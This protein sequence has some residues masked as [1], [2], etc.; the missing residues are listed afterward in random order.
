MKVLAHRFVGYTEGNPFCN[1]Q[2][3]EYSDS[4]I[5]K[6]FQPTSIFW[7]LFNE[8]H[9]LIIGSRGS[10]KT[11]LLKMMRFSMLKKCDHPIAN[12]IVTNKEFISMY[13]PMKLNFVS[14]FSSDLIPDNKR[15]EYFY[16]SFNCLLAESLINELTS[17]IAEY[18]DEKQFIKNN[19]LS[20]R[21]NECWFGPEEDIGDL[22]DL[23]EKIRSYHYSFKI[24]SD[25]SK[26]KSVFTKELGAT[27]LIVKESII[28]ILELQSTPKWIVCVDEAEFLKPLFQRSI[29]SVF[30][31]STEGIIFK[32]ATLP[33][34]HKTYKTLDENI[35]ISVGNDFN[36]KLIDMDSDSTDFIDITNKLCSNR[37][38]NLFDGRISLTLEEFVGKLG[39]DKMID[40]YSHEIKFKGDI[41][42][43]V[44]SSILNLL[45]D[46]RL[47]RLEENYG[48]KSKLV[49]KEELKK[50]LFDKLA[51]IFYLREMYKL[52]KTGRRVPG[53]YAGSDFIRKASQGNP[54]LF[55]VIMNSLFNVSTKRKLTPKRQHSVLFGFAKMM[56]ESTKAL[57]SNG[58][59]AMRNLD[60]I[61]FWLKSKTH[62]DNISNAGN[63]F[64]L[65]INE[66]ELS[67]NKAW[68]QQSVAHNRLRVDENSLLYGINIKTKYTLSN[69]YSIYNWIPLRK[70]NYPK[71]KP[72]QDQYKNIYNVYGYNSKQVSLFEGENDNV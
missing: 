2:S 52:S 45:S 6:E 8:Q 18:S 4:K 27:L 25:L 14:Y 70:Y 19:M 65:N 72:I 15:L 20:I 40:Y 36:F 44:E 58:P 55:I 69:A 31:G 56:C 39:N 67:K 7:D 35:E 50:P 64:M 5:I 46:E 12:K 71:I 51:P 9:E 54:R 63:T 33:F 59:E 60:N 23:R 29:N 43:H 30:R 38:S 3:R 48:E 47:S 57:E 24:N 10:G 13:V 21:L 1:P 37:L 62:K 16:F 68:I 42:Y 41:R 61:A 11:F 22:N 32:V 66:H 53:W 34:E 28:K 17:L 49:G 26:I